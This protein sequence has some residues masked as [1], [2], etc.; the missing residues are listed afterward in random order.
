MVD[1]RSRSLPANYTAY[2]LEDLVQHVT[3]NDFKSTLFNHEI[4]ESTNKVMFAK[5]LFFI[6]EFTYAVNELL[7]A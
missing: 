4:D 1:Y 2:F 6:G 7:E 5:I 3:S